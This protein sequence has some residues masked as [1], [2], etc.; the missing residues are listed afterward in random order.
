VSAVADVDEV[1]RVNLGPERVIADASAAED[2]FLARYGDTQFLL[3]KLQPGL[4]ALEMGLTTIQR[5]AV[6]RVQPSIRVMGFET[7]I[8]TEDQSMTC[9]F[10][11]DATDAVRIDRLRW[12]LRADRYFVMPM[13]KRTDDP[14][15]LDR[16]SVGRATNKDIV[17][18]HSSVSKF[19]AWFEMDE[20]GSIY[21]A[22]ADSTNGTVLGGK[23]LAVR[24]LTR[25]SPG[26]PMRF[27]SVECLCSSPSEFWRALRPA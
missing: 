14:T 2:R 27:G 10:D 26:E 6:Q 7:A 24:E 15:F 23:K 11:E 25:V 5:S 19:H 3:V 16:V 4:D 12:L 22:D 21:V 20:H 13:R 9:S 17:L 1:L 18:R 8:L